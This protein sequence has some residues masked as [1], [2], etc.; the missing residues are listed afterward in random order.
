MLYS[1]SC[2]TGR[3]AA[4]G[5]DD[6]EDSRLLCTSYSAGSS[7]AV[8]HGDY[9]DPTL[10]SICMHSIGKEDYISPRREAVMHAPNHSAYIVNYTKHMH[11]CMYVCMY[12]CMYASKCSAAEMMQA[13]R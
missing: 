2:I 12:V 3:F 1:N 11:T 13:G 9:I 4:V 8:N 10:A 7:P 5:T 6:L